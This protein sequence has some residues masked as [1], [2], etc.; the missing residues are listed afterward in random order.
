[1]K[2]GV[3]GLLPAWEQVDLEVARKVRAA[4]FQGVSIFFQRPLEVD[5]SRL[6]ALKEAITSAGLDVAQANGWYE[7][8]VHPDEGLRGEGIR[9][10]QALCRIGRALDAGSVYIRPGSLNPNGAW[11]PHPH[12]HTQQTFDRLVDSL[13]QVSRVAE[14]E[15]VLIGLEGHVL[16][17][18]DTVQSVR[19]VLDAVFVQNPRLR[20]Y[21]V[22]EQGALRRHMSVFVDGQQIVDRDRLSDPVRPASELYVMQALSGG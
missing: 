22:D 3:V 10:A 4:G 16:S 20:G 21:I 9:G 11:Y 18:L 15:G 2:L 13:R 6:S 12:N 17:P 19:D 8:L 5:F 1:M 14:N 7:V